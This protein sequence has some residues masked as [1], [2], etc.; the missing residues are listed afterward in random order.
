MKIGHILLALIMALQLCACSN[1]NNVQLQQEENPVTE[2]T[3]KE[4]SLNLREIE[5]QH[6]SADNISIYFP[7]FA[8]AEKNKADEINKM[9]KEYALTILDKYKD[10]RQVTLD[11]NSTVKYLSDDFL[12][13]V[14]DGYSYVD[15][16]PYPVSEFYSLNIDLA[17]M[18]RVGISDVVRIDNDLFALIEN[19]KFAAV[20]PEQKAILDDYDQQQLLADLADADYGDKGIYSYFTKDA[21]GISLSTLHVLGDHAEF[22][23]NYDDISPLVEQDGFL[24]SLMR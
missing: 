4:S 18:K 8:A 2:V 24:K 15:D 16:A 5:K 6:Y 23:C 13:I 9:V 19:G 17:E 21:V 7:C 12:S 10:E 22:E 1:I 3:G 20:N 14:F 11:I